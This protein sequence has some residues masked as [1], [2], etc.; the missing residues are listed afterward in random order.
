[1]QQLSDVLKFNVH[2]RFI[3]IGKD[4]L[5]TLEKTHTRIKELESILIKMGINV[6]Q[7]ESS[8]YDYKKDRA[9]ILS[10]INDA[11]RECQSLIE[12]FKVEL[13]K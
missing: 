10:Q 3:N 13:K 5:I 1:M 4:I 11:S 12:G 6:D 9:Y 8:P 7:Y 2:R